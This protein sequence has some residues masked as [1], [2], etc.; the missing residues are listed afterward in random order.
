MRVL[1]PLLCGMNLGH[2]GLVFAVLTCAAV[3]ASCSKADHGQ[4]ANK[5]NKPPRSFHVARAEMRPMARIINVTGTLAAQESS[6]LSAKLPGR[7]QQLTVD[8]GSIVRSG[9][10]LAQIEPRDYELGVQQAAAT[11][12]QAR[13]SLG[14]AAEGEDDRIQL[15]EVSTVKQAKAVLEEATKNRERIKDLAQSG[16]A[17]QSELDTTEAT[18]KVGLTRYSGAVEEARTRMSA[19][20]QRRAEYEIARKRLADASLRAPFDG[21]VQARSANLGEF[22]AAG[23]P[24]LQLVKTDPLRLRLAVPERKSVLVRTGQVVHLFVEGD[25]NIYSGRIA[26]LSPALDEQN[27][28][29]AIEADVPAKGSLRPGLFARADI[30]I[31]ANEPALT[32]PQNAIIT[33][34][35]LEKVVT[36]QQGKALEKVVTTGR[37]AGDAVEIIEGLNPDEPVVINPGGLRTG[38]PINIVEGAQTRT[39]SSPPIEA[40]Q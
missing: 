1:L 35:G 15:D 9:E 12:A 4:A 30:V 3:L 19:L 26:R 37:R 2:H 36:A 32:V 24:I 38:D 33:F 31:N 14:L 6:L 28:M 18:Y 20:A 16:V 23:T 22:V 29:L 27:R 25:T 34:A 40:G 21:V 10:V 8:I 17:S 13:A 5:S 7:L 11:L 39:E